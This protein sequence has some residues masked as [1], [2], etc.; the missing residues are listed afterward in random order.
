MKGSGLGGIMSRDQKIVATGAALGLIA[1]LALLRLLY[2]LVPAPDGAELVGNRLAFALKCNALAVLP[3]VAMLASI[4][5]ARALSEAIDPT[6][7]KEDAKIR[8]DIRVAANTL[9]QFIL[10]ATASMAVAAASGGPEVRIVGAA[11]IAFVLMRIAF[12]IGYR[13][14]PLYRAFGFASCF[15]LNIAMLVWALWLT[16]R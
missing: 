1:M 7:G 13:I 8:I 6:L 3:L 12:W 2:P 14:N 9:E 5:N 15:Y 16:L 4:G 10:F 11:A